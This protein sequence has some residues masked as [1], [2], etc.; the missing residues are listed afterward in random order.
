MIRQQRKFIQNKLKELRQPEQLKKLA[1]IRKCFKIAN[2]LT[3]KHPILEDYDWKRAHLWST[4][5]TNYVHMPHVYLSLHN[6]ETAMYRFMKILESID[7]LINM[8]K[9]LIELENIKFFE[10]NKCPK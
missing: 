9:L 3:Y 7:N 2:H 10:D 8:D 1:T 4:D 6:D 5:V